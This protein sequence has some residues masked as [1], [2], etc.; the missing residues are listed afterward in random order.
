MEE[1][2]LAK[3]VALQTYNQPVSSVKLCE[4]WPHFYISFQNQ[5]PITHYVSKQSIGLWRTGMKNKLRSTM[6]L[7]LELIYIA[8]TLSATIVVI[9]LV[10]I[11]AGLHYLAVSVD[12]N[13][14]FRIIF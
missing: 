1:T 10:V 13:R 3:L 12:K 4:F 2:S 9:Y 7:I 8:A 5:L 14:P 6:C 11:S